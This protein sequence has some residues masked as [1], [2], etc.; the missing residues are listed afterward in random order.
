MNMEKL[1]EWLLLVTNVAVV[2]G[3]VF[4]AVEIR[5]N[6][7][8]LKSGSRQAI[9]TND[10]TSLLVGLEHTDVISLLS[11]EGPLSEEEQIKISAV[12]L[13]DLR[14]R[15][16][17]YFQYQNGLLDEATWESYR[18]LVL[19]NHST[20][21]GRKCWD[22]VGRTTVNA[23]FASLVDEMLE[24]APVSELYDTLGN[25]NDLED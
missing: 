22:A 11:K 12:Y 5:Q 25:W 8:L 2:A 9:L 19:F 17:E 15:E 4:L 3:I 13:I 21:R 7:E 18:Q 14:N 1:N 23:D 24:D 6:N 20:P 16:F 10:Q